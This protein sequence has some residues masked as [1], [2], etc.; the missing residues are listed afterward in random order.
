MRHLAA[1]ALAACAGC[2]TSSSPDR[3]PQPEASPIT[4]EISAATLGGECGDAVPDRHTDASDADADADAFAG[5]L[6]C[7][8]TSMQLALRAPPEALAAKVAIKKVELVDAS[9]KV[10]QTLAAHHASRWDNDGAYAPWNEQLAPGQTVAASYLVT[11]P[12]W[13]KL[14]GGVWHA[15][16]KLFHFRVTVAVGDAVRTL[17]R[18][19]TTPAAALEPDVD[20]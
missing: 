1:C 4:V 20:T 5:D 8:P 6:A 3:P 17:D 11:T 13:G 12:D 2:Y 15:R 16:G 9:G 19:A 14:Y 18:L 7:I 10:L